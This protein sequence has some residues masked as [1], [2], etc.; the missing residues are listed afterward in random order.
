MPGFFSPIV[1]P[2][3]WTL[4]RTGV[5]DLPAGTRY[6]GYPLL[7]V[8]AS[9][10][11]GGSLAMPALGILRKAVPSGGPVAV[12]IQ[13]NPFPVRRVI[14]QLAL[15][16]P[17]FYLLL[18]DAS[19]LAAFMDGDT[20]EGGADLGTA[21]GLTIAMAGQDRIARHPATWTASIDAAITG[22]AGT[23]APWTPFRDA[24]IA[25]LAPAAEPP[26]ILLDHT[27]APRTSGNVRLIAGADDITLSLA[28][29]DAGDLQ[30]TVERRHAA[31]PAAVPR[32]QVFQGAASVTVAMLPAGDH[33]LALLEGGAT[34]VEQIVVPNTGGHVTATDLPTWFAPQFAIPAAGAG[35]ALARYTRGN[36]IRPLVDGPEFFD[37]LFRVLHSARNADGGFHLAGWAMFPDTDFTTKRDDDPATL[38]RTLHEA[39]QR[40]AAAGGAS[41]FLP[42][43]FFKLQPADSVS[44]GETMAFSILVTGLL[45]ASSAGV[46]FL[47]TD[48]AGAIVL[49]GLMVANA[50]LV[51]AMLHSG[52]RPLEPNKAAVDVL[53]PLNGTSALMAPFPADV[54]DNPRAPATWDFPFN[55]LFTVDRHFGVY[56]QKLSIVK[57][58]V[59]D[60]LGYCGGIDLNP[61]R[62]D[63]ARHLNAHPYHDVHARIEGPAVRDLALSF[64][65]RWTRDGGGEQ[66]AFATPTAASLGAPGKHVVQIARTYFKAADASRALAFA[67]EGDRT[68]NDTLLQAIAAARE[69]IYIED[70]Y[71][72]PPAAYRAA[73]TAKVASGAIK[74]LVVA[75]P[76]ITDQPFG[77]LVRTGLINDLVT[78]DA[79]MGI[80]RVG[81]PRRHYTL[82]DNDLRASSGRCLLTEDLA[83]GGGVTSTVCLG[84]SA[85]LPSPPF[86][87]AI[88]GE[89]MYVNDEA[90]AAGS[91][92]VPAGN[93][94]FA[95]VRGD[96][97][98]L[99]KGGVTPKGARPREHKAGAAATVV[100]LSNIYVHAKMMIVDDVF[101]SIGSA[102]LN[103]RGLFHDGEINAFTLPERL[104]GDPANPV[105]DLRV[106]LWAEMLDLPERVAA[107]LLADPVAATALFDRSPLLGNRY[108]DIGAYPEHV[109]FGVNGGDGIVT[110]VLQLGVGAPLV[111]VDHVKLFDAVV[112]PT[113][114][115]EGP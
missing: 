104:K 66:V 8:R 102:N 3:S 94:R 19:G 80:V 34:G 27:G 25:A 86:W 21:D 91:P 73:L 77:E 98:R 82:P 24:V 51:S 83:A 85:R 107:P 112:D 97:T 72:T 49:I 108:T 95:V 75:L 96:S 48:A 17:T 93:T 41:R 39:A 71:F 55:T 2:A 12:E 60:F 22:A 33:Q 64:E 11:G 88:D 109:M 99:I 92:A 10:T 45:M 40:I 31:D 84:P 68:I 110:T 59:D 63:D 67:P 78:A 57:R 79:G 100:D 9:K 114:A 81:Y 76:G 20:L 18:P 53:D 23:P 14:T 89:L 7:G 4:V 54:T 106:R 87:L 46:D 61:D 38:A 30:R 52:G 105:R 111:A 90:V 113:S 28:A 42:A 16:C 58:G 103:R 47:H 5:V 70:Q 1:D 69:F 74:R 44:V 36:L 15:G 115:L 35:P 50:V 62:L 65:Q 43:Q 6:A 29:A 56:H 13:V 32:A 37:D 101:L 26:V